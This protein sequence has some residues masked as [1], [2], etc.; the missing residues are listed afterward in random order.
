MRAQ[1]DTATCAATAHAELGARAQPDAVAACAAIAHACRGARRACWIAGA[2][3]CAVTRKASPAPS[4]HSPPSVS[5]SSSPSP[6]KSDTLSEQPL[7]AAPSRSASPTP[8]KSD[9][10]SEPQQSDLDHDYDE[11][12]NDLQHDDDSAGEQDDDCAGEQD[13]KPEG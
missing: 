13:D 3:W 4:C 12:D 10:L 8:S 2:F 5:S 1:P 6:S 9:T 11:G 7:S